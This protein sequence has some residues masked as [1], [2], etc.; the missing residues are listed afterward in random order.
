MFVKNIKISNFKTFKDINIDLG[1]FN[2]LVGSNASGKS[3]FINILKFVKDVSESG[4]YSAISQQGGIEYIR[5]VKIKSS[6]KLSIELNFGFDKKSEGLLFEK[7]EGNGFFGVETKEM[8][9][10]LALE[11]YK[12]S[13]K[14][15]SMNEY[16]E[17][18]FDIID[19]GQPKIKAINESNRLDSGKVII[20]NIDGKISYELKDLKQEPAIKLLESFQPK[21]YLADEKSKIASRSILELQT[22]PFLLHLKIFLKNL[23]YYDIDPKLSK[24]GIPI[25]GKTDLEPTGENLA[26]SLK[27][28]L[29]DKKRG[30]KFSTII[31]DILPFIYKIDVSTMDRHAMTKLTEVYAKDTPLPA[32]LISDGTINI[33]ALIVSLYFGHDPIII[34]EPERNIHPYLISK[35]ISMMKDVSERQKKQVIVTTHNPEIVKYAGKD[36]III[37]KRDNEGFT[38][39]YRPSEKKEIEVFLEKEMGVDELYVQNLL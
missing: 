22:T 17:M 5:N 18:S 19:I 8:K 13:N 23:S 29:A 38:E 2:I 21:M 35:I 4:L 7:N 3:N 24:K 16:Y 25:A 27:S 31:K 14:Y 26:I 15:K 10:I 36:Y 34:E 33:S 28:I 30:K 9:Y 20:K 6:K 12:K 37:A 11:F 32:Y 1:L 39:V